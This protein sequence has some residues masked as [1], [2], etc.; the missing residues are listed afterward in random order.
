MPRS[1]QKKGIEV[2]IWILSTSFFSV[3]GVPANH[4][5]YLSFFFFPPILLL[6][7]ALVHGLTPPLSN[8]A[9]SAAS[10]LFPVPRPGGCLVMVHPPP[11]PTT[12]KP[13]LSG[14][15]PK[16]CRSLRLNRGSLSSSFPD[17]VFFSWS[18]FEE[19]GRGIPS[20]AIS[21]SRPPQTREP[22][23]RNSRLCPPFSPL[24]FEERF[25]IFLLA[26]RNRLLLTGGQWVGGPVFS[27]FL[28]M[29]GTT[30]PSLFCLSFFFLRSRFLLDGISLYPWGSEMEKTGAFQWYMPIDPFFPRERKDP[31]DLRFFLPLSACPLLLSH[32]VLPLVMPDGSVFHGNCP[33]PR[34]P[35]APALGL[36]PDVWACPFLP[37]LPAFPPYPHSSG[38]LV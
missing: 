37:F 6:L 4:N 20:P 31:W 5:L 34:F 35:F 17:P 27:D 22:W 12:I 24:L 2:I 32:P 3:G 36:S 7:S 29:P 9:P 19:D 15:T 23:S 30:S 10:P 18:R 33:C 13:L 11:S 1:I 8:P 28:F 16:T 14:D 25:A 38:F 26:G 21:T